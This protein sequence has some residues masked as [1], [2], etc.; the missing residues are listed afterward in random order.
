M[1]DKERRGCAGCRVYLIVCLT[2][3]LPSSLM[4]GIARLECYKITACVI[5]QVLETVLYADRLLLSQLPWLARASV[6]VHLSSHVEVG[7]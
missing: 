1:H 4:S 2:H 3:Q 7:P 6:V 5:V